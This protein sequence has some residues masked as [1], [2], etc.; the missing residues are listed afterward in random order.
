M[1]EDDKKLV[2]RRVYDA[3]DVRRILEAS[4]TYG[5]K[6]RNYKHIA[7]RASESVSQTASRGPKECSS[8]DGDDMCD[9]CNCW[10]H[11]RAMCS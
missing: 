3:E 5:H 10:K 9:S 8:E 2:E 6:S 7:R 11:T 1:T 4:E